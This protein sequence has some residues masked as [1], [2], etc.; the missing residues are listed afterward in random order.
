MP[1]FERRAPDGE[2]YVPHRFPDGLY[3]VADPAL[4]RTKHH[5][6]N[7]IAITA[8]QIGDYLRRGFLLRMRGEKSGQVNLIAA[9]KIN[10]ISDLDSHAD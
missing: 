10:T 3:R 5:S 4:G 1:R 6:A 7:Q 2:R 9:S 8:E